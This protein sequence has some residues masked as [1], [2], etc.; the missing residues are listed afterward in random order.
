M[1]T[2]KPRDVSSSRYAALRASVVPEITAVSKPKSSPPSAATIALPIRAGVSETGAGGDVCRVARRSKVLR[3]HDRTSEGVPE[4]NFKASGK[5]GVPPGREQTNAATS[6]AWRLISS[7][8]RPARRP[9][10]RAAVKASPAPIVSLT[11]TGQT[12]M[13]GPARRRPAAGCRAALRVRATS[14]SP[15][16]E[17]SCPIASRTSAGKPNIAASAGSS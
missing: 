13:V 7:R 2:V 12:R 3:D 5:V 4:G 15:K 9:T 11:A 10:T 16:R 6:F 8:G 14:E 1:A 17:A